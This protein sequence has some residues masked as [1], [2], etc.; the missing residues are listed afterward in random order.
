MEYKIVVLGA[1]SVG[2][3]CLSVQFVRGVFVEQYDPT[4]EESYRQQIEID[5]SSYMLEIIDTAGTEN[6]TTMRNVYVQ[7]GHGFLLV[8]SITAKSTLTEIEPIMQL[9]LRI[10]DCEGNE[11]PIILVGNKADLED[12]REVTK[13]EANQL[14]EK[15]KILKYIETSARSNLNVKEVFEEVTR[16]VITK[17]GPKKDGKKDTSDPGKEKKK[18]KCTLL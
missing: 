1:G 14:V 10:K 11:I 17:F 3:S 7:N 9:I 6:F 4:V 13:E 12:Q 2:K 18:G 15:F 5:G 16:M 8:F